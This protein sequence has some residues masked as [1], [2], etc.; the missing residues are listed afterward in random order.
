MMLAGVPRVFEK[1]YADVQAAAAGSAVKR[2][3]LDWCVGVGRQAG[4]LRQQG[5]PLPLGLRLKRRLAHGLVFRKLHDALGGRLRIVI[6]GGAPLARRVG[7]SFTPPAC[8]S[9]KATA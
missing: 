8:P 2:A 6:S 3:V 1:I 5:R 9:W 7:E 4:R